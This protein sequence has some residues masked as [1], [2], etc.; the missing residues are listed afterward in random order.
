[1]P[2]SVRPLLIVN[3][4][5]PPSGNKGLIYAAFVADTLETLLGFTDRSDLELHTD[6]DT[7]AWDWLQIER[8]HGD[9]LIPAD[10]DHVIV[11]GTD[12]PSL[13]RAH[14]A[15]LLESDADVTFGPTEQG[16][17]YAAACT[18]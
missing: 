3:A 12:T 4:A 16:G 9:P 17:F 11:F 18:H 13:P 1:G 5:A 8:R 10:R 2:K 6:R 15:V 14:V 7:D